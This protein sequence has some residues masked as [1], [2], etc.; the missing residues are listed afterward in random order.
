MKRFTYVPLVRNDM[1]VHVL[2]CKCSFIKWSRYGGSD[3][4]STK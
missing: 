3:K 1:Y 4:I 2:L